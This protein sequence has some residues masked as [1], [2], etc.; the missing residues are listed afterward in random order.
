MLAYLQQIFDRDGKEPDAAGVTAQT[1]GVMKH[2]C[3]DRFVNAR[4]TCPDARV[5]VIAGTGD[6]MIDSSRSKKI[7]AGLLQ[8]K[9]QCELV[10]IPKVG[11][12]VIDEAFDEAMGKIVGNIKESEK[13]VEIL[14]E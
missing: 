3:L 12:V 14:K 6:K 8:K 11:H 4:G 2:D 1:K 7:A 10:L 5:L 9:Y 13:N